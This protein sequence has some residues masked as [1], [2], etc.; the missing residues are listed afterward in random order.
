MISNIANL[1]NELLND[2]RIRILG[3]KEIL[4]K[5]QICVEPKAQSPPPPQKINLGSSNQKT[6]KSKYQTVLALS[7][8]PD[9][10]ILPRIPR[11]GP[12]TQRTAPEMPTS[13][14]DHPISPTNNWAPIP[15]SLGHDPHHMS[16]HEEVLKIQYLYWNRGITPPR[17]Q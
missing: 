9:P 3:N 1:V 8:L 17:S 6:R 12:Q 4:G 14:T 7:S 10:R 15:R 11:P 16:A 13:A 5:S 2:L